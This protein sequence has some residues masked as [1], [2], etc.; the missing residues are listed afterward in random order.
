MVVPKVKNVIKDKG[1]ISDE[2]DFALMNFLLKNRGQGF[3]PCQPQLV[4]LEDGKE[5][6]KM[7]IDNTF[8]DKN[9]N[10]MGLGIVGKIFIDPE[11]YEILYA[12]PKEELDE[13][14]QK[15]ENAGIEPQ[16]RPKGKY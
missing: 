4:E 13:N 7:N 10:L 3:T 2:L 6:I 11:S 5:V 8:I 15:L 14:I 12:T 1:E 16:P 9:N